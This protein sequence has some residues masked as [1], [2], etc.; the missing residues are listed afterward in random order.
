MIRD[1]FETANR[2]KPAYGKAWIPDD[3]TD[4]GLRLIVKGCQQWMDHVGDDLTVDPSDLMSLATE[5][6]ELRGFLADSNK[7]L[8]EIKHLL[9]DAGRHVMCETIED[10]M[11]AA[12][13]ELLKNTIRLKGAIVF[14]ML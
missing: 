2:N 10:P 11:F 9:D 3:V 12:Y 13:I 6:V 7:C 8:A 1:G 5:L 4:D 14:P